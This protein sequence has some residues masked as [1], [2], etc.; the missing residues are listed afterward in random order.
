[1]MDEV[2]PLTPR[3]QRTMERAA[4]ISAS[5]GHDFIGT[6]H[7]LLALIDDSDGVAGLVIHH[8]GMAKALRQEVQRIIDSVGYRSKG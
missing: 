4:E 3:M 6:E 8:L 7:V 1:M 2:L 5:N